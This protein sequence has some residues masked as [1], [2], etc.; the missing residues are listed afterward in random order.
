MKTPEE[1]IDILHSITN[2]RLK[3]D[4]VEAQF[5]MRQSPFPD[6]WEPNAGYNPG[7]FTEQLLLL[8]EAELKGKLETLCF[9]CDTHQQK[10]ATGLCEFCHQIAVH[11][12]EP[13]AT[14]ESIKAL[15]DKLFP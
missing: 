1:I 10:Y 2:V 11:A 8:I 15:R 4:E 7:S 12:D 14:V 9:S 5:K 3:D 13:T 6:G